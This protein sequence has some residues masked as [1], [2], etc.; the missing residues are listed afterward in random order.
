MAATILQAGAAAAGVSARAGPG[1]PPVRSA[2][3][4]GGAT[5]QLA[6]SAPLHFVFN[7]AAGNQDDEAVL[8][9]LQQ[10]LGSA[11]RQFS[12]HRAAQPAA[13]A[14]TAQA[15]ALQAR[16]AG[17]AVVAVGGDGTI[18]TVAA[19]ARAHGV[20]L[21]LVPRGTFNYV[22][23]A[24]G[25][26]LEPAAA[27]RQL[28]QG[29]TQAV[30]VGLLNGRPFLVNASLGLYP[31]LL[32]DREAFKKRF[33]RTRLVALGAALG[34]MLKVHPRLRL[35]IQADGQPPRELRGSTLF[36]GNNAMQIDDLGLPEAARVGQGALAAVVLRA[37]RPGE[38]LWLA[39]RGALGRLGEADD[40]S[41]FT[42]RELQVQPAGRRRRI[43]VAMDGEV[44]RMAP[45]LRFGIDEKPLWLLCPPSADTGV[46]DNHADSHADNH[47]DSH[48]D[49]TAD[50]TAQR[51]FADAPEP[52]A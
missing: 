35:A 48:A 51:P 11:G 41:H 4:A 23:R 15:A 28:L 29:H 10:L 44:L 17:G 9:P 47:A 36:V 12:V 21:G 37:F 1:L 32:Q 34:T 6:A 8:Q 27:L 19:A 18:N 30:Q 31:Q 52:R 5:R 46:A 50:F 38:L 33:G 42:V 45:P 26:A 2:A 24:H 20:T 43:R 49:S 13:L 39:L 16:D 40:V 25:I 7:S 22:A 3:S 14:R